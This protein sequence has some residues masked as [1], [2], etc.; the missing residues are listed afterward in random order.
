MGGGNSPKPNAPVSRGALRNAQNG[1]KT[2]SAQERPFSVVTGGLVKSKK[3]P[4]IKRITS[5]RK[6]IS[7]H[8]LNIEQCDS[9]GR[10]YNLAIS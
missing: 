8:S 10:F 3:L 9:V 7:S 6:S 4:R 2:A 5:K 1:L